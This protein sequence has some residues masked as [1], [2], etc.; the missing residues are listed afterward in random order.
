MERQSHFPLLG[1]REGPGATGDGRVR[2]R[3]VHPP[4]LASRSTASKTGVP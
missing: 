4:Q 1:E 3:A 2:G